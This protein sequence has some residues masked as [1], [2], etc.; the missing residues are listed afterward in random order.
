MTKYS[1]HKKIFA[2]GICLLFLLSQSSTALTASTESVESEGVTP[3]NAVLKESIDINESQEAV[4][5]ATEVKL[6]SPTTNLRGDVK[7]TDS[8]SLI[9]L[10]LRDSDAKQV[11]RMFADK[12]GL[13]I[14]FHDSVRG[15]VTLDLVDVTLNDA[16]LLVLQATELSYWVNGNTLVVSTNAAAKKLGY[17]RQQIT[18]IPVK[19]VNASAVANFLNKNIFSQ[20]TPGI[21]NSEIATVN[22]RTNEILIFGTNNDVALAKKV[23]E[24]ID[25]KQTTTTFKVVHTT[26]KEMAA[27]VCNTF[28]NTGDGKS[29]T[30]SEAPVENS[31]NNSLD[32]ITLGGGSIA[33]NAGAQKASA[34]GLE[35]FLDNG[36]TVAYYPQ[37]GTLQIFGG[38]PQ[39]I[40]VIREFIAEQDKKQ[41]MAYIE[42]SVV[43]LNESGSKE[44]SNNWALGLP[45]IGLGL[46]FDSSQGLVTA[47]KNPLFFLGNQMAV[48]D[49]SDPNNIL[50][51]QS[52]YDSTTTLA[53]QLKYLIENGKGRV[54][55]NPKIMVTNGQKSTIDMTSD[56]VKTVK[57][58]VITNVMQGAFS[59]TYEIGNDEGLK[60]EMI[61]FISPE[62]YISL[63][64][65]PQFA[66]VKERIYA[67]GQSG[68]S[69]LQATLLQRRDL[70][71]KNIRIKD[72]E[73]LILGGLIRESEQQ[74][75][76]K[77]PFLGDLP[78]V[79]S[80]FRSSNSTKSKEELVIMITP[81]IIY[82]ADEIANI[83]PQNL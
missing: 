56:Y 27:L 3:V 77:I 17:Q 30:I 38:S 1:I 39:Q 64:L 50:Y 44:F 6:E 79:G 58:E 24:R 52:K 43:E 59:K 16:F 28:V 60:I 74:S 55:T 35:A 51:T 5:G 48:V 36:M 37:H 21:S 23:I 67:P 73:T 2:A 18:A 70:E 78:L 80:F 19:Y 57:S 32:K 22:P 72:G 81:H 68:V 14:I 49:P 61:P 25:T 83:K 45:G 65:Q 75:T 46:Q 82:G 26:P 33:C 12:A 47:P 10:S 13:N 20:N 8:T 63:N 76:T 66:T 4:E 42:V 40:E 7:I 29:T 15:K 11:L 34:K 53:L 54:L 31:S 41:P 71:L 9:T 69:E 62:G